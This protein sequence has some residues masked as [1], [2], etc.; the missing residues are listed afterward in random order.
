MVDSVDDTGFVDVVDGIGSD[1]LLDACV[2]VAGLEPESD[3][4]KVDMS[5]MDNGGGDRMK[6]RV[7]LES[8]SEL[9]GSSG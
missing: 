2:G 8:E 9:R 7:I 5:S 6:R 3:E 4:S 1:R